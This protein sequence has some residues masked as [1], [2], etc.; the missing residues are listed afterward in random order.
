MK[1]WIHQ[2]QLWSSGEVAVVSAFQGLSGLGVHQL[3]SSSGFFLN[4]AALAPRYP[5]CTLVNRVNGLSGMQECQC[6]T[7]QLIA[8]NNK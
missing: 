6:R 4:N 1:I 8:M 2:M 3:A 7:A 5:T